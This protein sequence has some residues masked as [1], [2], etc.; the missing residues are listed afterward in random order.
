LERV[1]DLQTLDDDRILPQARTALLDHGERRP[2]AVV[3]LHG[4]TNHPGQYREFAPLV[5]ARGANVLVPRMPEQGDRDR[6]TK[7]MSRLTAESLLSRASQAVDIACGLGKRVCVAG[8]SSSGLLCAYFAQYR[9]DVARAI[10]IA[11]VFA[12][13]QLPY[14]ASYALTGLMLALPDFY[15]WWDP[16]LQERQH[17]SSAYPWFSTR[18]L[19]QTMR[20]GE[21]VY[22]KA[23]RAAPAASSMVLVTNALDPAVNNAVTHTVALEWDKRRPGCVYEFAFADLPRNH[24]IIEPD[25]PHART[26]IVYPR[27]LEFIAGTP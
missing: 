7:R 10:C 8:I 20:L 22:A 11:P 5:H 16:R 18:A 2:L 26:D 17:P 15:L 9:A 19:A 27:L 14:G 23:K 1:R 3:L 25:N 21:N 4:F 6:L 13:L 24:D 12:M